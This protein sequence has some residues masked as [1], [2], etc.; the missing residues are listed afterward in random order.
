M[1][2]LLFYESKALFRDRKKLT[3]D[4]KILG[5]VEEALGKLALNPFAE[6]LQAKKLHAPEEG[7]FRLRC[8]RWR[9]LF[10]ID[11]KNQNII[12]YRMKQR[13]EGY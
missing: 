11:T 1:Y 6:G 5:F 7:T 10:D 3:K 12:I 2:R 8:G 9:I 13:K 4:K